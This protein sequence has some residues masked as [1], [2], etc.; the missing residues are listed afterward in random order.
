M[1]L[2]TS[3]SSEMDLNGAANEN[4]FNL[5]ASLPKLGGVMYGYRKPNARL[6]TEANEP[7]GCFV[8]VGDHP[9][10]DPET[11]CA[12]A[13]RLSCRETRLGLYQNGV[14]GGWLQLRLSSYR[15]S[16]GCL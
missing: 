10:I 5:P 2:R 8:R 13:V 9:G 15:M 7:N 4:Q 16:V 1:I 3:H 6:P 12:S 11:I 14:D